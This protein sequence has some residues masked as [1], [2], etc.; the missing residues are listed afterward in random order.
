[1]TGVEI[2]QDEARQLFI[3]LPKDFAEHI[4]WEHT[5]FPSFYDG[6]PEVCIR[7]STRIFLETDLSMWRLTFPPPPSTAPTAWERLDEEESL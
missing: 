4:L 7:K 5:G 3:A 2:V 6:D 1:V